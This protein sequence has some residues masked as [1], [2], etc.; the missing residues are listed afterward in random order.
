[1]HD[2][3]GEAP[4]PGGGSEIGSRPATLTRPARQHLELLYTENLDA[5]FGYCRTRLPQ[6]DAED[7]T[8]DVFRS[9]A[10]HL[11]K[12]PDATL[13]R[14]WLVTA[15]RNRIIDRWRSAVRWTTRIEALRADVIALQ[16]SGDGSDGSDGSDEVLLAALDTLA[17]EHRAVLVLRFVEGLSAR[18]VGAILG[19]SASAVDSL[20]ARAKQRVADVYSRGAQ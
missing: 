12:N 14:S 17:P 1:V 20:A 16:S 11:A 8:A 2:P 18:Q 7:V 15:A 13:N 6:S 4:P 9:A 19:R 5:V 3:G 10:Q